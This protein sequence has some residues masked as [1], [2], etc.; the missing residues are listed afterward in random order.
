MSEDRR[1]GSGLPLEGADGP[2]ARAG[3]SAGDRLLAVDGQPAVDVLDLEFAAADGR[4]IVEVERENRRFR[5]DVRPA[6][7]E[8]HGLRLA[9]GLG[10][11][12]R[13]CR[14]RCRFC[15]VDQVPAGLR[16]ALYVKDDDY[17]LSFLYGNFVTLS[18]MDDADLAR[19]LRLRLSPLYVSL[20]AW[21]DDAR[22]ALMGP[23]ARATRRRLQALAAA[24]IVL[25][26]QV[27]LC[28]GWN[29]G[30]ILSET[31][32]RLAGTDGVAD[33]GVVPVSLAHESKLRRVRPDDAGA[34]IAGVEAVQSRRRAAAQTSFAH[35]ADEL[36]LLTGRTP[37]PC[38][39]EL[40]YENGVGI[41]DAFLR[42]AKT[43]GRRTGG[44]PV[45]LL[46]GTLAE[47]VVRRACE[48]IGRARPYP[49]VNRLFGPHVTVTG[50]LGGREVL[51]ALR[52]RPAAPGEWLLAPRSFL[53]EH[54][55]RTLD[56]IPAGELERA[57]A[58]RLVLAD[59]LEEALALAA[60]TA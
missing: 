20:H 40:Q 48:R 45:A 49:V 33:V 23:A 39:A 44:P 9:G 3:L 18:N 43:L 57:A 14:N 28:P 8:G 24:G 21:D 15:F 35:A 37:P 32:D 60:P 46:C 50:L 22:V 54:L 51:Q 52:E 53:P 27:V 41:V 34:A 1:P 36:Y 30:T 38:D 4:F 13:T 17:R 6:A 16:P 10:A 11:P 55:G 59:S 5:A 31:L 58:G 42:E 26:V 19:V 2:A 56:D 47:P 25:H 7:G 29:D 12:V